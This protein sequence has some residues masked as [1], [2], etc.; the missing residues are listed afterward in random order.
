MVIL[1]FLDISA[2]SKVN[3]TLFRVHGQF[4]YILTSQTSFRCSQWKSKDDLFTDMNKHVVK[5]LQ[6]KEEERASKIKPGKTYKVTSLGETDCS[7]C[8]KV[9]EEGNSFVTKSLSSPSS[10][11]YLPS[12]VE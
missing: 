11:A 12:V 1:F 8:L 9:I 2:D 3:D 6:E 7:F 10:S 5:D 4:G